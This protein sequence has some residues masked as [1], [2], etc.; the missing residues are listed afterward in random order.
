VAAAVATAA[1]AAGAIS[2]QSL[3]GQAGPPPPPPTVAP[4][5]TARGIVTAIEDPG[6][7]AVG[8][9]RVAVLSPDTATVTV[10]DLAGTQLTTFASEPGAAAVAV[11][12]DGATAVV[13]GSDFVTVHDLADG[14][15]VAGV[16]DGPGA[17]TVIDAATAT[18]AATVPVGVSPVALAVAPDSSRVYVVDRTADTITL[19]QRP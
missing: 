11:S 8:G 6:A 2:W 1:L 13:A 17:V 18:V 12:P 9:N 7:I 16:G 19:L 10:F 15:V 3:P 4:A 14:R 5:A